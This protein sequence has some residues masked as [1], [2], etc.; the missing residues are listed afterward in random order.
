MF[1][2]CVIIESAFKVII[3]WY[4]FEPGKRRKN[5]HVSLLTRGQ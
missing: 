3:S 2:D 4:D 1:E 5:I